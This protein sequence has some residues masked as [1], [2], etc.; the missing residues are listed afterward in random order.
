MA[1]ASGSGEVAATASTQDV[2][3]LVSPNDKMFSAENPESYF[4]YGVSALHAIR[5]AQTLMGAPPPARILD[6][7]CGHGRVLR[8][9][10]AAYP[11]SDLT[12][13]DIDR[14]GVDF[15]AGTFGATPV[16]SQADPAK[17]RLGKPFDLIWVGSLLTHLDSAGWDS[18]LPFFA[19]HLVPGGLLVV[20][21][22]GRYHAESFR[23]NEHFPN[24]RMTSQ[25]RAR[26]LS[27]YDQ[28]GFGYSDYPGQ[29][30][31]GLSIANP[32]YV[33]DRLLRLAPSLRLVTYTERACRYT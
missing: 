20:T 32:C 13:C 21:I 31:Y 23:G 27:D 7:P 15:C 26:V 4:L 29:D 14:D 25:A 30:G 8:T 3:P 1:S 22:H 17:V 6:M 28:T 33:V 9:L 10:K 12:A 2:I 24:F 16:Y 11:T 5:N 19:E 18:F